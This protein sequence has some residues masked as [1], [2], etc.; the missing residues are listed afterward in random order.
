MGLSAE[1]THSKEAKVIWLRGI[2]DI[3]CMNK[4]QK[5]LFLHNYFSIFESNKTKIFSQLVPV[6]IGR[7]K[8]VAS[9]TDTTQEF[10]A[11]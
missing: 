7:R 9:I 2:P 8:L 3:C 1:M 5:S 6:F 4:I 11:A 10:L